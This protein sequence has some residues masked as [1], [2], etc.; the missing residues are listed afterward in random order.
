MQQNKWRI[1]NHIKR[2]MNQNPNQTQING[3]QQ[4]SSIVEVKNFRDLSEVNRRRNNNQIS[5]FEA[6]DDNSSMVMYEG[7]DKSSNP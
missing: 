7:G 6:S 5:K 2:N 4:R 1:D 3:N